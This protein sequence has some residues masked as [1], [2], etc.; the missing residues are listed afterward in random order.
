MAIAPPRVERIYIRRRESHW[1]R[2]HSGRENTSW[3]ANPTYLTITLQG[4]VDKVVVV[5][6][7]HNEVALERFIFAIKH[8]VT[9]ESYDRDDR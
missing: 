1:R 2:T 6:K 9:L 5:I 4:N 3:K 8:M 7:D